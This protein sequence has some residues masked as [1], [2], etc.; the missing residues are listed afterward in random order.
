MDLFNSKINFR[1]HR[2]VCIIDKEIAYIGSLNISK[3]H[4]S[5]EEGGD[6]WRDTSVRLTGTDLKELIKAFN[7]AWYHRTIKERLREIFRQIRKDPS[8]V[9]ITLATA[10]AF[11]IKIYSVKWLIARAAFGLPMHILFLIIFY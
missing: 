4:L 10:D 6:G 3:Y 2:K 5:P 7:V 1:N 8:F 9:S 11:F